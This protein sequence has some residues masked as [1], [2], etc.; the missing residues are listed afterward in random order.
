[1]DG[2]TPGPLHDAGDLDVVAVVAAAEHRAEGDRLGAGQR[3]L[4][5]TA[6]DLRVDVWS[7]PAAYRPALDFDEVA[8]PQLAPGGDR[9]GIGRRHEELSELAVVDD[10]V[11]LRLLV[12]VGHGAADA[13]RIAAR[14]FILGERANRADGR[15]GRECGSS[16]LGAR[17]GG[18]GQDHCRERD[19]QIGRM[20]PAAHRG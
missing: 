20:G 19:N 17:G 5:Q 13:N 6:H 3:R 2:R 7:K 4:P 9:R 10:Q 1:M 15:Q 16:P 8:A 12:D 11:D 14:P 18:G